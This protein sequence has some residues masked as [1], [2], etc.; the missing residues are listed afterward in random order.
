M[1]F[2]SFEKFENFLW[3]VFEFSESERGFEEIGRESV[4]QELESD[5]GDVGF[6]LSR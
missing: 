5:G 3:S 2:D 4:C 6:S 1:C